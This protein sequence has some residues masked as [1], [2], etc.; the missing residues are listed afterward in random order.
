MEDCRGLRSWTSCLFTFYVLFLFLLQ[1]FK[2]YR[3]PLLLELLGIFLLNLWTLICRPSAT[4]NKASFQFNLS[5]VS[6]HVFG[7]FS[8]Q[9]MRMGSC[10]E[11]LLKE[12]KQ[13]ER[14]PNYTR[15]ELRIRDNWCYKVRAYCNNILEENRI[16]WSKRTCLCF[17]SLTKMPGEV[18][19]KTTK[20]IGRKLPKRVQAVLINKVHHTKYWL[21]FMLGLYKL[22]LPHVLCLYK[23]KKWLL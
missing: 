7:L 10:Q 14:L 5:L 23:E 21:S 3:L 15:T 11:A 20:E 8:M 1:H 13:G 4:W 16:K 2:K 19:L 9:S 18:F 6:A 22:S 17:E 12:G